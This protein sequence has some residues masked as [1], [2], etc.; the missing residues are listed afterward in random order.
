MCSL[1]YALK[2]TGDGVLRRSEG[3]GRTLVKMTDLLE[4]LEGFG[5]GS[6]SSSRDPE[7][8]LR[9]SEKQLES[10]LSHLRVLY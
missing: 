1:A 8:R 4:S 6:S 3:T 2:S 5:G 10:L 9:G 7:D